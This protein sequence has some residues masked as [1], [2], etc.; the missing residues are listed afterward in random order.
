MSTDQLPEIPSRDT[1]TILDDAYKTL[2]EGLT[3]IF[4]S[5]RKE[6]VLA[7]GH[8][9][10]RLRTGGFLRV[11]RREL[12]EYCK[13]G[14]I[15]PDY[16]DTEQ[17]RECLQEMLD[18]LDGDGPDQ[19]RFT[20]MK[21]IFLVTA[22]ETLSTRESVL[23]QQYMRICRGLSSGEVLVLTSTYA[24]AKAGGALPTSGSARAWLTAI[25]EE[26]G[27]KH[28]ELVELH[29]RT[30]IEK[31][32]LTPRTLPDHSGIMAGPEFRLTH[33]GFAVCEFLSG[34]DAQRNG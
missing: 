1:G 26:S 23:P 2:I 4:A 3:G 21:K 15:K 17:H 13:R 29:E 33:L 9:L 22:T 11:L 14:R 27:L 6:H 8:V 18:F 7:L 12:Q 32:M 5:D 25:A 16:M 30:L 20:L 34:Y 10:Q 24:R 31:N 28:H 19:V